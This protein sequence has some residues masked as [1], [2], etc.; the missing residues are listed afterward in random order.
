VA[1][2]EHPQRHEGR[3]EVHRPQLEWLCSFEEVV[4]MFDMDEARPHRTAECAALFP[5]GKCKVATLSMKDPNE[6]LMAGKGRRVIKRDLASE[7][8]PA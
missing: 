7:D 4:L 5:P 6:L 8:L 1:R 2:G 3:E